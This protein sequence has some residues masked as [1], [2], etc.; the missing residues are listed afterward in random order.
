MC[1]D[2]AVHLLASR[3]EHWHDLPGPTPKLLVLTYIVFS[4][5]FCLKIIPY[6]CLHSIVLS[7]V[8][9]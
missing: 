4:G 2:A 9:L 1:Q 6:S 3:A 5:F 7:C 8:Q